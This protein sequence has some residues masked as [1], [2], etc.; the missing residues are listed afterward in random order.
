M[1]KNKQSIILQ[2][3]RYTK[4]Y[5][6][7]STYFINNFLYP[8]KMHYYYFLKYL[9]QIFQKRKDKRQLIDIGFGS[10]YIISKISKKFPIF[11]TGLDIVSETVK[12]Y[13]NRRLSNSKALQ[14]NPYKFIIP[15]KS[16]SVDFVICSHVLEHVIDDVVVL[17]EIKRVIKKDGVI[18]L[19]V[20]I[21]EENLPIPNHIR[22]YTPVQFDK[23]LRKI[24]FIFIE[25][26]ESDNFALWIN[27]LGLKSNFLFNI[28]KKI[29]IF[30]L[31]VLP[32][33]FLEKLN[34]KKGQY[35]CFVKK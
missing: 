4:T 16:N 10:G 26:F 27:Y 2:N 7:K 30:G 9:K 28:C 12:K 29:L 14:I 31:S 34:F 5:W 20:P 15:F 19:N 6:A 22:K 11:S 33:K 1:L 13:N 25:N 35:I 23:K 32:I 17:Q 3:K 21:N 8:E 18:Y 24:K